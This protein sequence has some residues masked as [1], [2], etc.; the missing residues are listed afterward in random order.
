[1]AVE[2]AEDNG[3]KCFGANRTGQNRGVPARRAELIECLIG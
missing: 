3:D 1:M 2:M